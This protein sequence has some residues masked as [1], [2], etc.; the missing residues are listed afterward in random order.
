MVILNN[1]FSNQ[2]VATDTESKDGIDY[3]FLEESGHLEHI[4]HDNFVNVAVII[5]LSLL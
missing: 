2:A 5:I 1:E 3:I 4:H